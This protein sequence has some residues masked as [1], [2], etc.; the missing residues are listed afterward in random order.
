MTE[1]KSFTRAADE[2]L[3]FAVINARAD[4]EIFLQHRDRV[5]GRRPAATGEPGREILA[6]TPKRSVSGNAGAGIYDQVAVLS[7]IA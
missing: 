3:K 7:Y 1:V 4:K 5:P 6:D 2:L